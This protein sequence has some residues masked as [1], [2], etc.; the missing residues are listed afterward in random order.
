MIS[1][2]YEG[3]V[4]M[5]LHSVFVAGVVLASAPAQ[6]GNELVI[7]AQ[8]GLSNSLMLDVSGSLNAVSVLQAHQGLGA[9]NVIDVNI[10]GDFNGGPLG[11]SF[12]GAILSAGLTPGSITQSGFDDHIIA[13]VTG[14]YNLFAFAQ[15][16]SGDR[17]TASISG[18]ANQ[19][20]VTQSGRNNVVGFS[21]SG[22]GNTVSVSQTSW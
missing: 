7:L 2:H 4:T 17:L 13:S 12:I 20:A 21:Q 1:P 18:M 9:A 8:H 19:A 6:A 10:E 14:S 16:G 22:N 11:P 5:N 15:E 3:T